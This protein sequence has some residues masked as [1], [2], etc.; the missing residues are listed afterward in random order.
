MAKMLVAQF[1]DAD[2]KHAA[3]LEAEIDK[4]PGIEELAH[5]P[6][7]TCFEVD[8]RVAQRFG[9]TRLE[10]SLSFIDPFG[11]RG[12]SL[13]MIRGLIKDWG[14][15]CVFF[16][17]YTRVNPSL[18]NSLMNHHMDALFGKER[19]DAL[20]AR[21][22]ELTPELR[23]AAILEEL[24]NAIRESG[25][26]FVLPFTFKSASGA[27]TSHMLI[28]VTKHILGYSI[29][30]DIMAR[31]SST[32]DEGV[33]S[34]CYSPADAATP[35]LFSLSQ[36]LGALKQSLLEEFAGQELGFKEIY[37]SHSVDTPYVKKN[38]REILKQLESD[39]AIS[40][41]S[42]K[43]KRRAGTFAGHVLVRFPA[44]ECNGR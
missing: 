21:L 8:D 14:C 17:N 27:R 24:A 40:A 33:P 2:K 12:L 32:E 34:F 29:M 26:E 4:L 16:F 10:P 22:P 15:D 35:W 23:Q 25:G 7:V 9:E 37:E 28:F 5:R 6:I 3:V 30:K 1:N 41:R 42:T 13:E 39:G 19:A 36:P 43:G 18:S 20:R 31:E 38:Y 44:G 11:Y